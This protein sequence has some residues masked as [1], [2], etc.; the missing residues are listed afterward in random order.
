MPGKGGRIDSPLI[1]A[2][3]VGVDP[4]QPRR[5]QPRATKKASTKKT[6]AKKTTAAAATPPP[7]PSASGA[8]KDTKQ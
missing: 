6:A 2:A 8:G 7:E 4:T 1:N 3:V 5:K